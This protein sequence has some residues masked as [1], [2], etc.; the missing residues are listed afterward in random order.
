[1]KTGY[2][3]GCLLGNALVGMYCKCGC[4]D[5]SWNT[6]LS[7]YARHG[8]LALTV[9]ESMITAGVKPD[10]ITMVHIFYALLM[11]E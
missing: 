8:W 1:V 11:R 3:N 9:F 7:G 5:G 2:E 4:I 10:E 6:M